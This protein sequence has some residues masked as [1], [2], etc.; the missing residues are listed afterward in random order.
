M[1]IQWMLVTLVTTLLAV[2]PLAGCRGKPMPYQP[3]QQQAHVHEVWEMGSPAPQ[4]WGYTKD[5]MSWRYVQVVLFDD[6][7]FAL[8]ETNRFG[9]SRP[10]T[11]RSFG[12][13]RRDE[14][15]GMPRLSQEDGSYT[16]I[17]VLYPPPIEAL[18]N[19]ELREEVSMRRVYAVQFPT[20][21]LDD[22]RKPPPP[23][24]E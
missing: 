22:F 20:S 10:F 24:D 13:W 3:V 9:K 2:L 7:R 19:G 11:T 21:P 14:V 1:R 16:R 17:E 12:T 8:R 23:E 18:F 5:S 4:P 6:G 15:D